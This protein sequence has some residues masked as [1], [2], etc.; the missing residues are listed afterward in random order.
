[1]IT[2]RTAGMCRRTFLGRTGRDRRSLSRKS[3]R[4][5]S[6]PFSSYFRQQSSRL[7]HHSPFAIRVAASRQF[8]RVNVPGARIGRR[9][10]CGTAR[11][12]SAAELPAA[13]ESPDCSSSERTSP[14]R[15]P[16]AAVSRSGIA[17][18]AHVARHASQSTRRVASG[19]LPP[20]IHGDWACHASCA[21]R[22]EAR[23]AHSRA[24][25]EACVAAPT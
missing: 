8:T 21:G 22:G 16:S 3:H 19:E 6:S 5:F 4:H 15:V 12:A 9:R 20:P 1:V 13:P 14:R 17:G 10:A 11:R 25:E 23:A 18:T 2:A 7:V 24:Q